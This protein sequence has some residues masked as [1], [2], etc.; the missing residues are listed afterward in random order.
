MSCDVK[1]WVRVPLAVLLPRPSPSAACFGVG[2]VGVYPDSFFV[3][4]AVERK[5]QLLW[6]IEYI[7]PWYQRNVCYTALARSQLTGPKQYCLQ[8]HTLW[9]HMIIRVTYII[10]CTCLHVYTC[11]LYTVNVHVYKS[12]HIITII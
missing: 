11:T 9:Y 1:Q 10:Q 6:V 4:V 12:V 3:V 8:L 7:N 2:G 5:S